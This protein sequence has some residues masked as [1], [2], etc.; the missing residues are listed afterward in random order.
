MPRNSKHDH[1][2]PLA[3]FSEMAVDG[4]SNLIEAQ[5]IFLTLAQQEND[6]LLD[7]VKDRLSASAPAAA[8]TDLVRRSI[9][10][11][12]HMQQEFLSMTSKEAMHWL[13]AVQQG[14]GYEGARMSQLAGDATKNFVDAH[15]KVLDAV[16]QE[17]ARATGREPAHQSE[18]G[19]KKAIS[20]LATEAGD[21]FVDAQKQMLDVLGQQVNGNIQAVSR[22]AE[23]L[24]PSLVTSK[25][26]GPKKA[27]KDILHREEKLVNSVL[28]PRRR[29][30]AVRKRVKKVTSRRRVAA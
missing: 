27:V 13:E 30:K 17:T 25:L 22:V 5:R 24:K 7:G 6:L 18:P 11:L 8:M 19:R 28:H 29:S 16:I 10:I 12:I 1:N 23:S 3:L 4:A 20:T 2:S 14:R 21:L 9:D 26:E 15:R